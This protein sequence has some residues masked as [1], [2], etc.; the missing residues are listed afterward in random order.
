MILQ[1]ITRNK[2]NLDRGLEDSIFPIQDSMIPLEHGNVK[3]ARKV[4][5]YGLLWKE[6]Y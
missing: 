1:C 4:L 5:Y 6:D 3:E 2:P